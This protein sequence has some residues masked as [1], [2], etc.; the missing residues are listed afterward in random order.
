MGTVEQSYYHWRKIYG[1][2]KLGQAKEYK[3]LEQESTC[4]KKQW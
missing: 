4:L 3:E 2:I 1:G